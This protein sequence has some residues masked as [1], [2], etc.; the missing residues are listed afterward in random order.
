MNLP[1]KDEHV[2]AVIEEFLPKKPPFEGDMDAALK[3]LWLPHVREMI[4]APCPLL[5]YFLEPP[6]EAQLRAR[7]E[8]GARR[9]AW[10]AEPLLPA[11]E[12]LLR[13]MIAQAEGD[14]DAWIDTDLVRK[15]L[16]R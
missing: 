12:H 6:T 10:L 11:E 13:K 7:E 9:E 3:K 15:A 5:H 2:W 14:F 16:N 4:E 8:A 1:E